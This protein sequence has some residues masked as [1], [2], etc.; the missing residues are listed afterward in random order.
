VIT[1]MIHQKSPIA[2]GRCASRPIVRPS[3]VNELHTAAATSRAA[4]ERSNGCAWA[5]GQLLAIRADQFDLTAEHVVI[6]SGLDLLA[7]GAT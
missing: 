7:H 4:V 6:G 5:P 3:Y 2:S 1:R